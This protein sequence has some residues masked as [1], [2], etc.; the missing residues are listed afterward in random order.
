MLE[1]KYQDCIDACLQ[2]MAAC[3]NCAA[4]CAREENI[5]DMARCILLDMECAEI[6]SAAASLM[7]MD[8]HFVKEICRICAEAC[9]R[10]ADE[11]SQHDMD[12]CIDCAEACRECAIECKKMLQ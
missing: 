12:H 7:S 9:E 11:C 5:K 8:G 2:C 6:C 1:S 10:C 3:N 4:S